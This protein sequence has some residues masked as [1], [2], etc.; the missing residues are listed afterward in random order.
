MDPA[1]NSQFRLRPRFKYPIDM[2]VE[3]ALACLESAAQHPQSSCRVSI[4]DHRAFINIPPTERHFWSP[5]MEVTVEDREEGTVLVGLL[6]PN[7]TVWS[8]FLFFYAAVGVASTFG[9]V[10][11]L[12]LWQLRGEQ[13]GLWFIPLAG[14]A[15]VM[16]YLV[17][18][19]G[20]R[21]GKDQMYQLYYFLD[22]LF[23]SQPYPSTPEGS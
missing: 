20:Q 2:N 13:W 7:P 15:F 19:A 17:S 18:K 6:G 16:V 12:T 23:P 11:G 21:L 3:E 9:I 4:V 10:H 5:H 8:L 14:L 22:E 1:I